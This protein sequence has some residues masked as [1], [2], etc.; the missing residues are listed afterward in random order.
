MNSHPNENKMVRN[1]NFDNEQAEIE[2]VMDTINDLFDAEIDHYFNTI[3][4]A[5]FVAGDNVYQSAA[6]FADEEIKFA[7]NSKQ[8]PASTTTDTDSAPS[9]STLSKLVDT[10]Q[11]KNEATKRQKFNEEATTF[12]EPNSTGIVPPKNSSG[13]VTWAKESYEIPRTISNSGD[14]FVNDNA[15]YVSS[16]YSS[17][18]PKPKS[19]YIFDPMHET[20]MEF[21][22]RSPRL[23]QNCVN[24][25]DFAG[26]KILVDEIFVEDCKFK[27]PALPKELV[28]RNVIVRYW[29]SVLTAAPDLIVVLKSPEVNFRVISI[30]VLSVG[31]SI[32][33]G[34]KDDHLW[35]FLKYG[36]D[37]NDVYGKQLKLRVDALIEANKQVRFTS[38]S[39][40]HLV[41]NESRTHFER[42]ISTRRSLEIEECSPQITSKKTK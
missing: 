4:N 10:E 42:F 2:S 17:V 24:G 6:V 5:D 29:E 14:G 18:T 37:D 1:P 11:I 39:I 21:L 31:T 15:T 32:L 13:T 30:K 26:L 8:R 9:S 25:Y 41:L 12:H 22:T 16:N 19:P 38:R 20:R 27:T 7:T 36:K 35:N 28:G 23:M 33:R 3:G 40:L 34:S